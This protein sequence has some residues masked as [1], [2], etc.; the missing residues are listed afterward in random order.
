MRL[1]AKAS[2]SCM[3]SLLALSG[4]ASL[5]RSGPDDQAIRR[6]ADFYLAAD[7]RERAPYALVDLTA[8]ILSYFPVR[9]YDSFTSGFGPT[10]RGAPT[11]PLGI[12]DIVA[13]T[14]FES[15]AGGLFIPAE[16]GSRAG[17]FVTL[18]NQTIDTQG[19]I[20]VPYAGRIR[21]AGRLP[22]DVQAE[23]ERRL[24]DRAIEPQAII[25]LVE[26]RSGQVSVLGDVNSSARVDINPS[27]ERVLDAISKAGGLSAPGRET[28]ITLQRGKTTATVPFD[29]LVNNPTENIFLYPGDV[30]YVNRERRTYLAFG[31][32]GQ[33]G[34]IDFEESNLTLA[35]GIGKAGGLL[36]SRADPGQV[37]LYR[38]VDADTLRKLGVPFDVKDSGAF[39]V[40]FRLNMR[41]PRAMFI[42]QNFPM[43][44]KDILYVSNANSVEVVKFFDI[45]NSV[46]S[47]VAGPAADAVTVRA[48]ERTLR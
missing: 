2:V 6:Q 32:T 41:D 4:C 33:S 18:P 7:K 14:L 25:T 36:D 37:F 24:A 29:Q 23:I 47:G 21:A 17:N 15:A 8:N 42:A 34:R 43:Q 39:P 48:A 28:Y 31:A 5:P 11:L 16:A 38:L 12:G 45:I 10:R 44:D 20:S 30:V 40:V 9:K 3:A 27:G 19:T 35:E 22:E 13:V 1:Y 26:S 46:S